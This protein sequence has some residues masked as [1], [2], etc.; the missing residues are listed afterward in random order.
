VT[1]PAPDDVFD[2]AL[3]MGGTPH[4]CG[5]G[6]EVYHAVRS[7]GSWTSETVRQVGDEPTPNVAFQSF[8]FCSLAVG[9]AT[10]VDVA[11]KASTGGAGQKWFHARK[12]G[13][14]WLDASGMQLHVEGSYGGQI[15]RSGS[16]WQLAHSTEALGATLAVTSKGTTITKIVGSSNAAAIGESHATPDLVVD[17]LGITH[18]ALAAQLLGPVTLEANQVYYATGTAPSFQLEQASCQSANVER[19][20]LAVDAG[21]PHLVYA[22]LD[23]QAVLHA[24]KTSATTWTNEVIGSAALP[25]DIVVDAQGKAHVAFV[26]PQLQ[27]VVMHQCP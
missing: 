1:S 27:L 14:A 8:S 3:D 13:S 4:V 23:A 15:Q 16:G 2:L 11:L 12:S 19:V 5:T 6:G 25:A 22:S 26:N 21:T 24:V 20:A 10:E 9:G 18:V 17:T 7:G